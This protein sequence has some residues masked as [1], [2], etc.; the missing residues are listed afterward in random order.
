M[1]QRDVQEFQVRW[2]LL[3]DLVYPALLVP[4]ALQV[5]LEHQDLLE[6][7]D[8]LEGVSKE[9]RVVLDFQAFQGLRGGMECLEIQAM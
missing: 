9:I 5:L 2:E 7:P 1:V 8:L 4:M 3:E 6:F